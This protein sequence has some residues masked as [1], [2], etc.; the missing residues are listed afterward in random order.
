MPT[1]RLA[2]IFVAAALA[3][4]GAH[5]EGRLGTL[6]LGRYLC[7]LPGDA[8]GPASRPLD[9]AWF[10]VVNASSYEAETGRGTYLLTGDD[11]VFTRGP[12]RGARFEL[13]SPKTLQRTNLEGE[14]AKMRCIRTGSTR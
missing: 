13:V 4:P 2:A 8:S 9:K 3:T 5:A 11:V 12:M 1:L 10:D 6:P 14:F 7:E